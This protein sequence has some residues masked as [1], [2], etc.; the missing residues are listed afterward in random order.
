MGGAPLKTIVKQPVELLATIGL[1]LFGS[2]VEL[3]VSV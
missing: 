2:G 3:E 1:P